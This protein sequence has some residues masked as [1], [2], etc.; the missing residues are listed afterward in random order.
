MFSFRQPVS[1]SEMKKSDS[2]A[3]EL[4]DDMQPEPDEREMEVWR[5]PASVAS[6]TPVRI[7]FI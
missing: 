3:E 7:S 4:S 2:P 5:E 6:V 1:A